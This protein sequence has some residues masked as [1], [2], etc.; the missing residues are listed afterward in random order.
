[1]KNEDK[2]RDENMKNNKEMLCKIGEFYGVIILILG[3]STS[4]VLGKMSFL[5]RK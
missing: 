2:T 3:S 1:M 5:N 4:W